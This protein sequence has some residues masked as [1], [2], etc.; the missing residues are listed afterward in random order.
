MTI[1]SLI[2]AFL[3]ASL[4]GALYHLIRGG[5]LGRLLLFLILGWAGFVSGYL[6]GLWK[7]WLLFPLGELNFGLSSLGSLIFLVAGDWI[8]QIRVRSE[9]FSD[10][11]NGV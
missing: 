7:G 3:I 2:F 11:E 1:P 9:T 6:L 10:D 8:S 5:R 4:Y